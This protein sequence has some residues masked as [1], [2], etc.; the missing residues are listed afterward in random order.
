MTAK[1]FLIRGRRLSG[2]LAALQA[3]KRRAY[4]LA[5]QAT[6]PIRPV[7]VKGHSARRPDDSWAAYATLCQTIE[8][9]TTRLLGIQA[10]IL[11]VLGQIEDNFVAQCLTDYYVNSK[12]WAQIAAETQYSETHLSRIIHARGL[13]LVEGL[14]HPGAALR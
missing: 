13:R 11:A 12:T 1:D 3:C 7:C 9:E 14:L 2:R 4:A 10:E 8:A 5:T 6:A